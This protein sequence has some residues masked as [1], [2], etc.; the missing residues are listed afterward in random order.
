MNSA[1]YHFRHNEIVFLAEGGFSAVK[2]IGSSDESGQPDIAQARPLCGYKPARIIGTGYAEIWHPTVAVIRV[3]ERG[4]WMNLARA[5]NRLEFSHKKPALEYAK[6]LQKGRRF[7][8][9]KVCYAAFAV[10]LYRD[11][12]Y[13]KL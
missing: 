12:T 11:I 8:Q 9:I 2:W 5:G 10:D 3:N 6:K 13:V 1:P 7:K 4:H